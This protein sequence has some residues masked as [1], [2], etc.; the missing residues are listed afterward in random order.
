MTKRRGA[1]SDN[2]SICKKTKLKLKLKY[3]REKYPVSHFGGLHKQG[4][5]NPANQTI[6][7][8]LPKC[9]FLTHA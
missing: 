1:T 4:M 6:Y 9:H 5:A 7:E 8:L 3:K 2:G